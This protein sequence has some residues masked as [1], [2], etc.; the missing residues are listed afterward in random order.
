MAEFNG[1]AN[2][3]YVD[4]E[5]LVCSSELCVM[6]ELS[7]HHNLERATNLKFYFSKSSNSF[8]NDK[9][10]HFIFFILYFRHIYSLIDKIFILQPRFLSYKS[11]NSIMPLTLPFSYKT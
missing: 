3:R 1:I 7:I 2:F 8:L 5:A 4:L 6:A 11:T 10:I 9:H